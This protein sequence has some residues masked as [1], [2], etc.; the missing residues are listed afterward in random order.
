[1]DEDG[2][3]TFNAVGCS[4]RGDP[5]RP[6]EEFEAN[7]LRR[8]VTDYIREQSQDNTE[9]WWCAGALGDTSVDDYCRKML[10]QGVWGGG[11]EL[12]CLSE[13]FGVEIV[14]V[15][16]Q[17][18]KEHIF[19]EEKGYESRCIILFTG[20]HY[21]RVAE[22]YDEAQT[23][24]SDI[25]RWDVSNSEG[26][27]QAARELAAKLK[28]EMDKISG[29]P[30]LVPA[31][32]LPELRPNLCIDYTPDLSSYKVR[33]RECGAICEGRRSVVNHT[34][35]TGHWTGFTEDL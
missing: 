3:C 9:G 10:K 26:V 15:A 11:T 2:D 32:S 4:L 20:S 29:E 5:S 27:M 25:T 1:M 7:S 35:S 18:G 8:L 23:T 17:T 28:D 21:D 14:V 34:N 6:N 24:D 30:S 13:I 33:C 16:I 19:G 22:I 31:D 12:Q